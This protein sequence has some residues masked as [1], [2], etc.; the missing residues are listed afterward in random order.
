[1]AVKSRGLGKGLDMIFMENNLDS[2]NTPVSLK[3]DEIE[4]NSQQPRYNFQES[5]LNELSES[6]SKHGVI[7]PIIVKP[8][9]S[10][11]YKII[12][13]ERRWRASK[14]AGL[15]EVPVI[16]KDID[17]SKIMEFALVENLQREDLS[18]LEEAR[19]YKNL[20]ENYNFTHEQ[21][22]QSVNKSRSYI[23]NTLRLL[24]LPDIILEKLENQ[25]I[26]AGHARTLLGL[27]NLE[28]LE[29]IENILKIIISQDLSVRKLE[30]LVKKINSNENNTKNNNIIN[31]NFIEY[32]NK[33]E[34]NFK[35]KFNR[36]I[37]I[38]DKYIKINFSDEQDFLEIYNILFN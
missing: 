4:P 38:T 36:N 32:K 34:D 9:V 24:N 22:S 14:R 28:N 3:I 16:I 21:V 29:I 35:T 5:S 19:G 6:I 12:A 23:T 20:I 37:K 8:M 31:K 2:E 18:A 27:N 26:S 10:G 33:F 15:L 30:N 7:Q 17:D 1:M 11:K 13:G 25:E